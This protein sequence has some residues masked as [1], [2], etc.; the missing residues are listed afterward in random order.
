M[1]VGVEVGAGD[2]L[3]DVPQAGRRG[4]DD[5]EAG[6]QGVGEHAARILDPAVPSTVKP[7]GAECRI[8]RPCGLKL[9]SAAIAHVADMLRRD[10]APAQRQL[11]AH[12]VGAQVRPR[13]AEHD[14][15]DA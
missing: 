10:L 8:S 15:G 12:H 4:R 14:F 7:S 1:A 9:S 6:G 5:Q 2:A 3:D 13:N 11:G